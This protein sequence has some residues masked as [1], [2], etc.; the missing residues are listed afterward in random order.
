[1][2]KLLLLLLFTSSA[3]LAQKP[4]LISGSLEPLQGQ[5]S[6][7]VV[8]FDYDSIII[9]RDI[10]ENIFLLKK[11]KNWNE[12]EPG[13]GDAFIKKWFDDRTRL[14]EPAFISNFQKNSSIKLEDPAAKYALIL[15]T[16][17]I[18]GGWDV[19][20]WDHAGEID[21]ILFIVESSDHSKV[22]ATI[23][24]PN[25]VGKAHPAGDF[26]MTNRIKDAYVYAGKG[27]GFFLKKKT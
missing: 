18:E 22:I 11:E 16:T 10:P 24:F 14:Y 2:K 5:K 21:A 17:R 27:F 4:K 19:F 12:K 23:G 8:S 3:A 1:M 25:I 6:Y 13:K 15:K 26:E 9:G 20:A 7:G